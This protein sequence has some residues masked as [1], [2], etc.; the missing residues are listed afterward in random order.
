MLYIKAGTF[1]YIYLTVST[2][3][4]GSAEVH[5]LPVISPTD[6]KLVC[7]YYTM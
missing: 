1:I 3:I 5:L 2:A 6:F 7:D 4:T